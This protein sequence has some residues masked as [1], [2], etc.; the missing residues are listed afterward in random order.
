MAKLRKCDECVHQGICKLEDD[1]RMISKN[2]DQVYNSDAKDSYF[3]VPDL[4]CHR[5][6]R[7]HTVSRTNNFENALRFII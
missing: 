5:F 2:M 4:I 6:S 3:G 1:Y 7:S